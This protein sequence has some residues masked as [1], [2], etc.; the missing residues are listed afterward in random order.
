MLFPS[1]IFSEHLCLK[2]I[3]FD[4]PFEHRIPVELAKTVELR[5]A[6]VSFRFG[7]MRLVCAQ[8]NGQLPESDQNPGRI[9]ISDLTGIFLICFVA[10]VVRFTL[11]RSSILRTATISFSFLSDR[12]LHN[13]PSVM[14]TG[15]D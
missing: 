6:A 3:R 4:K 14:G 9:M 2:R 15:H 13:H 8:E 5:N 1:V 12:F 7:V 10:A 11:I